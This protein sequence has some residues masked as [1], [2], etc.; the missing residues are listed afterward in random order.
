MTLSAQSAGG[1]S[2]L[3]LRGNTLIHALKYLEAEYGEPE[4]GRLLKELPLPVRTAL[5][6]RV[7][8]SR[9]YDASVYTSLLINGSRRFTSGDP[10]LAER[11][12]AF[13]MEE[14]FAGSYRAL[15]RFGPAN[16]V[17]LAALVWRFYY[18]Q[19][20]L[21]IVESRPGFVLAQ[22]EGFESPD[23]ILCRHELMA[24]FIKTIELSG[25]KNVKGSHVECIH[26]AGSVCA[27]ELIWE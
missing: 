24:G 10:V 21:V 23:P 3:K 27:Y 8:S 9:W 12:S 11:I 16:I 26:E 7:Y 19:G 2:T 1:R 15:F 6:G 20:Q 5:T 17:R 22:L 25:G 4:L 18:N 13:D 14:S